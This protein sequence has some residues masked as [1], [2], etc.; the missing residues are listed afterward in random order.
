MVQETTW[1][2]L[3]LELQEKYQY[4]VISVLG[5][6]CR[7]LYPLITTTLPK[8]QCCPGPLGNNNYGLNI[9][10]ED[11]TAFEEE[12]WITVTQPWTTWDQ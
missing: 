8:R 3:V 5:P 4:S 2:L 6:L 7:L 11:T 10:L 9:C 12:E 1:N